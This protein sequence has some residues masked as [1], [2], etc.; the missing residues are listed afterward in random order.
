MNSRWPTEFHARKG[1]PTIL[2]LLRGRIGILV[3]S[4]G[5]RRGEAGRDQGPNQELV[6]GQSRWMLREV[7]Q[8][9]AGLVEVS[10]FATLLSMEYLDRLHDHEHSHPPYPLAGTLLCQTERPIT[11]QQQV[12]RHGRNLQRRPHH[13]L[14]LPNRHLP[15]LPWTP[16]SKKLKSRKPLN[17]KRKSLPPPHPNPQLDCQ[18]QK[19][20][21]AMRS[22]DHIAKRSKKSYM[23]IRYVDHPRSTK[24]LLIDASYT[25]PSSMLWT[26]SGTSFQRTS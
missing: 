22:G 13:P 2:L 1:K 16:S 12:R 14:R 7:Q 9:Q 23:R 11:T 10:N 25:P 24:T 3:E 26:N 6:H 15:T 20:R 8:L 21:L 19:R 17:E 18:L 5:P 4:Q